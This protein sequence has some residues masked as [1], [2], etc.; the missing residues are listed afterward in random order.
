[1]QHKHEQL[2]VFSCP[3]PED[4]DAAFASVIFLFG[5]GSEVGIDF[6]LEFIRVDVVCFGLRFD[7]FGIF[8]VHRFNSVLS[9][10]F[11]AAAIQRISAYSASVGS[12][13][14]G[15]LS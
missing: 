7:W 10:S 4:F 11:S 2:F 14:S 8:V 6:T 15:S 5:F 3:L 1:M 12:R 13:R 9:F